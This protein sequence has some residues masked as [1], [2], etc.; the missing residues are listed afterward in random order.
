MISGVANLTI[1]PGVTIVTQPAAVSACINTQA[2]LTIIT[3]G[4][5]CNVDW[6]MQTAAGWV[7]SGLSGHTATVPTTTI[8]TTTY[9]AVL[10]A[11]C[12]TL[13]ST[14]VTVTVAGPTAIVT[15][16]V[17]STVCKGSSVAVSVGATGASVTY[18]W[19]SSTDQQTWIPMS[20]T[21]ASVSVIATQT[22]Y[23]RVTVMGGGGCNDQVIST[24]ATVTVQDVP[25]QVPLVV[26]TFTLAGHLAYVSVDPNGPAYST[27]TWT[28]QGQT[29]VGNSVV[30]TMPTSAGS[31]HLLVSG[32]SG[33]CSSSTLWN[34]AVVTK[35]NGDD[36]QTGVL[37]GGD[38]ARLEA[39]F[40][41]KAGDPNYDA[42]LDL[43]G[44]GLIDAADE[45]IFVTLYGTSVV[46]SG[47]S[48]VSVLH[49]PAAPIPMEIALPTETNVP[50]DER[51]TA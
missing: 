42:A 32:V 11:P 22:T 12:G 35:G 46:S 25:Q 8:G 17:S 15:Q 29:F 33:T 2:T 16:P 9:Q 51:R 14:P 1:Q 41:S 36:D 47:S 38:F 45:A 27:V 31:Y 30:L 21:T 44:D 5:A 39:C 48:S 6:Q 23:Y 34:L 50:E 10:T 40:G 37:D 4:Q 28:F 49:L 18:A 43:N 20:A 13:L 26:P 19:V 3:S 24:V 7:E